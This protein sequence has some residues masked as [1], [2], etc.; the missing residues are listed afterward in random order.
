MHSIILGSISVQKIADFKELQNMVLGFMF[1]NYKYCWASALHLL[2]SSC[3]PAVQI[4]IQE[5][6]V[7]PKSWCR[8]PSS[9]PTDPVW[10]IAGIHPLPSALVTPQFPSLPVT[11]VLLQ[12]TKAH[13]EMQQPSPSI[14]PAHPDIQLKSLP[15]Y[16]VL[17]VLLLN[18]PTSLKII[19]LTVCALK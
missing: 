4:K 14:P 12:D 5:P 16:N 3:S 15:F 8:Y 1:L 19:T 6:V 2:K 18:K 9:S 17:D 10:D 7:L 13:F 11:F